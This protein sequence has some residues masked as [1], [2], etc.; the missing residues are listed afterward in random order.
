[1][2]LFRRGKSFI[3]YGLTSND[4]NNR[5]LTVAKNKNQ[6]YE[7]LTKLLQL[8]HKE[9]FDMWCDLRELDNENYGNWLQ[10]YETVISEAEKSKFKIV[11]L[12]Y[13]LDAMLSVLRMFSRCLPLG[14]SFETPIEHEYISSLILDAAKKEQQEVEKGD[15]DIGSK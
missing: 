10:Y 15:Q 13:S 11:K 9:H 7:Y 2:G 1:M 12:K 3:A 6:V 14:C 5:F 8:E 4:I